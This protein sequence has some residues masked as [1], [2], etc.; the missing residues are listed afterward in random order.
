MNELVL[1]VR[2][3][4]TEPNIAYSVNHMTTLG[5]MFAQKLRA[6]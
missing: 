6:L 5:D 3:V 2:S 1:T 4:N